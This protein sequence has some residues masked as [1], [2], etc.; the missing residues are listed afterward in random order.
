MRD[1]YRIRSNVLTLESD[2]ERASAPCPTLR[3]RRREIIERYPGNIARNYSVDV[4][5]QRLRAAVIRFIGVLSTVT[6][7]ASTLYD[8]ISPDME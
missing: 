5:I 8:L 3:S 4:N 7:L 1:G 6:D 2:T